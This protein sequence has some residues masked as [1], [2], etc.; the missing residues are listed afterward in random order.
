MIKLK[1]TPDDCLVNLIGQCLEWDPK[2]RIQPENGLKHEWI[3]KGLP[4][5]VLIQHSKA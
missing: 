4:P 3:L 1:G 5:K 2:K